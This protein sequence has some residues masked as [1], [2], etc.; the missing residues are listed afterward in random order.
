MTAPS[1]MGPAATFAAGL[2]QRLAG[3]ADPER[4]RQMQACMTHQFAFFGIAAPLRCA[5]VQPVVA[6]LGRVIAGDW[7]PAARAGDRVF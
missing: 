1:V 3:E 4:A 7:L 2:R 6:A 5:V